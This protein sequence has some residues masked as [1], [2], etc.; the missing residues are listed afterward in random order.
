MSIFN[1]RRNNEAIHNDIISFAIVSNCQSIL[2]ILTIIL[3]YSK[4]LFLGRKT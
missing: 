4:S 2:I 3:P 1:Y